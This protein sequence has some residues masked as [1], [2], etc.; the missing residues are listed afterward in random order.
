M[1]LRVLAGCLMAW[2]LGG[3][4]AWAQYATSHPRFP[5]CPTMSAATPD[6]SGPMQ[7]RLDTSTGARIL[8]L[9][10]GIDQTSGASVANALRIYAPIDEIWLNS[11]GGS[12]E[13]GN[14]IARTIR[15]SGVPVHI[16][17]DWW[18][19]SACNFIFFGGA[20]RT[21]A[22]RG[23]IAVHMATIAGGD[24]ASIIEDRIDQQGV[25]AVIGD[26]EQNMAMLTADDVDVLIRMGISRNLLTEVMYQQ[27]AS[28][29][30]CLTRAEMRRYNVINV[31]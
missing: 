6:F 9:N 26:V 10:G 18:C 25:S 7:P 28:G 17:N 19:V 12:A 14:A 15:Q 22:P 8:I 2:S 16:P 11:G 29:I 21:I 3:T 31:E 1:T 24:N 27:S 5:T 23:V 30:R 4:T 13:A 20:I